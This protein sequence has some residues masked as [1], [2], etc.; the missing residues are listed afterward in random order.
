ML[1]GLRASAFLAWRSIW[2]GSKGTFALT[3]MIIA[4][5]FVNLIFL[6]SILSGVVETFDAQSIDFDI[7]N[8]IIEPREGSQY[9]DDVTGLQRKIEQI[10]GIVGTSPRITV[11]VTYFYRGRNAAST[12]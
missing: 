9:I 5:V 10:P 1:T 3:T 6:P 11:G 12:L 8:L 4:L 2:R 7:G